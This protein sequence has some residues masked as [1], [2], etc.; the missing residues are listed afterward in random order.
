MDDVLQ[1]VLLNWEIWILIAI[2]ICRW[3]GHREYADVKEDLKELLILN[4]ENL[5]DQYHIG[6]KNV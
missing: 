6:S 1:R 5:A 3:L 4:G 2:L